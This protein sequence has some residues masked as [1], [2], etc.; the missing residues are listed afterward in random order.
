MDKGMINTNFDI[1]KIFE[2]VVFYNI[3]TYYFLLLI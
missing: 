3:I 2:N 1:L